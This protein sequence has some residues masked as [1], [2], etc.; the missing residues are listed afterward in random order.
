MRKFTDNEGREWILELN[1]FAI[2][3]VRDLAEVDLLDVKDGKVFE[4]LL[5]DPITLCNVIYVIC[6]PEADAKEISDEDFGRSMA[7]DAIENATTALL[8]ELTDFFP[9][10]SRRA[11][12]R[13][14]LEKLKGLESLMIETADKVMDDPR[15]EQE[16]RKAIESVVG[17]SFGNSPESS[18][19]IPEPSPSES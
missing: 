7:G 8:E 4:T 10:P 12:L 17:K 13:K 6:K 14:A 16:M 11:V 9:N 19:S 18:E 3:R 5:S 2:K 1:V 15:M